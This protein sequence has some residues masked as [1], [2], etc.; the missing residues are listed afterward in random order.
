MVEDTKD[1]KDR[2]D[3]GETTEGEPRQKCV[4]W[5]KRNYFSLSLDDPNSI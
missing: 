1:A 4:P 5:F 2:K 3:E